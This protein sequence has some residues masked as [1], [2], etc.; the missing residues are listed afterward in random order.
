MA[1]TNLGFG[2]VL[3]NIIWTLYDIG[4]ASFSLCADE[5]DRELFVFNC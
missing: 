1:A 5:L 3:L 2:I 4:S